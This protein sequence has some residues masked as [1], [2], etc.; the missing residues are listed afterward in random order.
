MDV[1]SATVDGLPERKERVDCATPKTWMQ[2]NLGCDVPSWGADGSRPKRMV[3]G[4]A[5]RPGEMAEWPIVQHWKCCVAEMSPGV[6]IPLS[7]LAAMC[8]GVFRRSLRGPFFVSG[9]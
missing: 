6:R 3:D 1:E 4:A 9:T 2:L 5:T 8:Y 7:P